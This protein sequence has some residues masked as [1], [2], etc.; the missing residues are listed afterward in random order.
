MNNV[1]EK[2][3]QILKNK[4]VM[5]GILVPVIA[6]V[7]GF[8]VWAI[9][10]TVIDHYGLSLTGRKEIDD[11]FDSEEKITSESESQVEQTNSSSEQ[12]QKEPNVIVTDNEV[13]YDD[14][15]T[16]EDKALKAEIQAVS[17]TKVDFRYKKT[18]S[19][20]TK[21]HNLT[22]SAIK[23][24]HD[25]AQNEMI[26]Y[27]NEA[28]DQFIYHLKSGKLIS[29]IINSI[30]TQKTAQ[31]ISLEE[32]EKIAYA[33]AEKNCDIKTHFLDVKETLEDC[34]RFSYEADPICGYDNG[35]T[36]FIRVGFDGNIIEVFNYTVAY[37]YIEVIIDKEKIEAICERNLKNF[38]EG[39]YY[40]IMRISINEGKPQMYTRIYDA[41]TGELDNAIGLWDL[42]YRLKQPSENGDAVIQ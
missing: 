26:T 39:S 37:D 11:H 20:G 35:N 13:Q 5:I 31:S 2:I 9:T 24:N 27:Q 28:G 1:K 29:A 16:A 34:Y 25:F 8:S 12:P 42:D 38:A 21:T 19:I 22:Y 4:K 3:K 14:G 40:A 33:Y 7:C 17:D 36:I 15:L 10:D 30:K 18:E 32:A 23:G 6:V 41:E